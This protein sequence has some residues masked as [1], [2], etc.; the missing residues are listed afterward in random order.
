MARRS[1]TLADLVE[2]Y[3]RWQAGDSPRRIAKALGI[4][5]NTAREYV[6]AAEGTGIDREAPMTTDQW[7][8]FVREHFPEAESAKARAV[9][10]S[11]LDRYRGEIEEALREN[12]V[13][14]VWQRMHEA[15]KVGASLSTFRRYVRAEMLVAVDAR[16]VVIHGVACGPGELAQVDFGQLGRVSDPITG[17][18]RT[19]HAFIMVLVFSRHMFAWPVLS[20]DKMTWLRCHLRAFAFFGGVVER[21]VLD[22][23]KDGVIRPDIYD[24]KLNR[25]YAEMAHHYGV[26]LDPARV[27]HP[28][29]K[30]H[31]ERAVPY[32]REHLFRGREERFVD[33]A[34]REA[35]AEQWCRQE[36]GMRIHRT[37]RR[38]PLE[39]FE[40]RECT[41]LRPLPAHEWEVCSW[42]KAKV[43]PDSRCMVG[44]AQYSV[45]WR[46]LGQILDVKVTE[47]RV[48]FY[49]E[50]DLVKS[51][52]R[53]PRGQRQLDDAD[54]PAER[55]AFFRQ[56]RQ[57]CREQAE[58]LGPEVLAAINELLEV[59]T[60]ANLRQ[61]QR[62]L[63]LEKT[64]GADR[65]RAACTR[66]CT[67]RDP[68]YRT[69]QNILTNGLDQQPDDRPAEPA[70]AGAF[71]R[72]PDAFGEHPILIFTA[73]PEQGRPFAFVAPVTVEWPAVIA[74]PVRE[75][76]HPDA[77]HPAAQ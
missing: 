9:W 30:P 58:R 8:Q 28:K 49:V 48:E 37:T 3:R 24:P 60:N 35:W 25:A 56:D 45:P 64:Y 34:A 76:V 10:W 18:V 71:L 36:A 23:L 50:A 12:R 13:T 46:L 5:R 43:A 61:A 6:R 39:L 57:W 52:R 51:H 4:S 55:L 17:Q 14:T 63:E 66:A 40:E 72:G 33:P 22:N 38:R 32:V 16:D 7:A 75:E 1:F 59:C 68:K 67:Y 53:V 74:T 65:L 19:L 21:I 44:G 31:V 20:M 2:V 73:S 41:A 27:V 47:N 69:I 15:G 54:L 29:D 26:L 62:V 77:P 42:E 70:Q 11:D